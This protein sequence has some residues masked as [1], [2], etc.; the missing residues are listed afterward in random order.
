MQG[1]WHPNMAEVGRDLLMLGCLQ[2]FP[3]LFNANVP[4]VNL[5]PFPTA[6]PP[7]DTEKDCNICIHPG[8][9][10]EDVC[11]QH[12][13]HPLLWG[14]SS[15]LCNCIQPQTARAAPSAV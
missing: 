3:L 11:S 4:Y 9:I 13:A 12:F 6:L 1:S 5:N 8:A 15:E 10:G 7:V 14:R 2:F